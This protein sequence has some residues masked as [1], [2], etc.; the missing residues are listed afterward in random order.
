MP[1]QSDVSFPERWLE[2]PCAFHLPHEAATV[3][4]YCREGFTV[5]RS[6]R[7]CEFCGNVFHRRSCTRK[8]RVEGELFRAH[9][10]LYCDRYLNESAEKLRKGW[11]NPLH[12]CTVHVRDVPYRKLACYNFVLTGESFVCHSGRTRSRSKVFLLLSEERGQL[13]VRSDHP[14]PGEHGH[15]KRLACI[16]SLCMCDMLHA[17]AEEEEA[18]CLDEI[19]VQ[20]GF[21]HRGYLRTCEFS[22]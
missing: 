11:S 18:F 3:C 7:T 21:S 5:W 14:D 16:S 8:R 1:S 6:R 20:Q 19:D 22:K 12:A 15:G 17:G 13:V 2:K 10:C 4:G 9:I